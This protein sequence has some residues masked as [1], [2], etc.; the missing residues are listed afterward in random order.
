[1][2]ACSVVTTSIKT[3][4]NSPSQEERDRVNNLWVGQGVGLIC[5][6]LWHCYNEWNGGGVVG[7]CTCIARESMVKGKKRILVNPKYKERKKKKHDHKLHSQYT[8][9]LLLLYETIWLRKRQNRPKKTLQ[10]F[11]AHLV[12]WSHG[13]CHH[14]WRRSAYQSKHRKKQQI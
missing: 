11:S 7:V 8:W 1:M 6:A 10:L 2:S 5:S 14:S 9:L 4:L 3:H 13:S 12:Q